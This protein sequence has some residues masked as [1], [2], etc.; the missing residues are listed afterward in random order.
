MRCDYEHDDDD[1]DVK[2]L[3]EWL[4]R[5]GQKP[6]LQ[7]HVTEHELYDTPHRQGTNIGGTLIG[8]GPNNTRQMQTTSIYGL[9]VFFCSRI[10]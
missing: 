8:D 4:D 9:M 1:D 10:I 2:S 3:R 5:N 7:S 6:E